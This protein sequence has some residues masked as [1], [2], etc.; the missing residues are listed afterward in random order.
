MAVAQEPEGARRDAGDAPVLGDYRERERLPPD[1]PGLAHALE[2]AE[3]LGAAAERDVLAVVGRRIRVALAHRQGLHRAAE[4]RPRLEDGDV[5]AGFGEVERGR[6]A[7]KA[8]AHDD[9]F[10]RAATARTLPTAESR[11]R[12]VKTS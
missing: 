9:S 2:E 8:S 1:R 6:E 3:V 5:V 4:G 10:H 11:G 7:G 12:L